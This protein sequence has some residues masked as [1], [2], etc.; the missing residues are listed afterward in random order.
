MPWWY[1]ITPEVWYEGS[2]SRSGHAG[3]VDRDDALVEHHLERGSALRAFLGHQRHRH[4]PDWSGRVG[5]PVGQRLEC[6]VRLHT[7]GEGGFLCEF[8]F[9]N[10]QKNDTIGI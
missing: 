1:S 6:G 7:F 4:G 3:F 5:T 2:C 8:A 9:S 10:S